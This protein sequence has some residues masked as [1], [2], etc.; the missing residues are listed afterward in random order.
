LFVGC[1]NKQGIAAFS[2]TVPE[3]AKFLLVGEV[4]MINFIVIIV[5]L[6]KKGNKIL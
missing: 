2:F 3:A 1:N 5:P 4:K 6:K